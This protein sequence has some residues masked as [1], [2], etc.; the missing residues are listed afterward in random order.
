MKVLTAQWA[1]GAE[2]ALP[3][4][5]GAPARQARMRSARGFCRVG[6]VIERTIRLEVW[7]PAPDLWNGRLLGAG[8]G[9]SAGTLNYS[10]MTDGVE[11]GFA[12]AST[13]TGH[14][15]AEKDWMLDP[16]AAR[17]Y[18]DRGVH[19][20]TVAAKAVIARF[21]G[22][23]ARFAYFEGCS[24]GGREA[25]K[26]ME[27]YPR[28]YNGVLAGAPGVNM[29]LL[30]V[31]HMLV[32]LWQ[33]DAPEKL[34]S[35]DWQL[36]THRAVAAC[37]AIDGI[38]DGVLENPRRCQ[39][40]WQSLSC[41]PGHSSGCLSA[42]K[43]ALMQKIS[44]PIVTA[45]GTVVDTGL[46]PGVTARPG[47]PP[48]LLMQLFGQGVHHDPRWDAQAFDPDRDLAAVYRLYPHFRADDT[49]LQPFRSAGGKA[50]IYQGWMD[51]SVIAMSTVSYYEAVARAMGG[52]E[53]T[54]RFVRLFV[55][56]GM[57][58]CGR[59]PGCDRFGGEA[60]RVQDDASHDAL[61]AL[62]RWVERGE[63]PK[64]LIASRVKGSRVVR[65]RL[66]CPY[67][68]EERYRGSG[69]TESASSFYCAMPLP[70]AAAEGVRR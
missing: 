12:A 61:R 50:I 34:T 55:V 19:L 52:P 20:M 65:T 25:M 70:L 15:L 51:P 2:W 27:E 8:V 48:P 24:G 11:R 33:Q 58:H 22:R 28:D 13:D 14:T 56:P 4:P 36:M 26:E 63:A 7:L 23:P 59:G 45:H 32:G 57:F 17:N 39:V 43:L 53:A 40:P 62:I 64:E 41:R 29:P 46:L 38:K 16:R 35:A 1:H 49:D 3:G 31:R 68:Q 10:G 42:P 18:A 47:P 67:P 66:L 21:Y 5:S 30:S 69:S 44:R 6:G 37:D 54:D 60:G 9:G